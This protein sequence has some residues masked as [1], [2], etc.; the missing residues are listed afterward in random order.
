MILSKSN[1]PTMN[2]LYLLRHGIAVPHG[3]PGMN[4][5]DRP[6]TPKGE[7][8]VREVARGLKRIAIEVDRIATS[9]LPR[10]LSTARI[11]AQVI[12]RPEL[13]EVFDELRAGRDAASIRAWLL[14]RAEARLMI[15]G[16]NPT[17]SELL[18]W[19]TTGEEGRAFRELRKGGIAALVGD[20]GGSYRVD[21]IARPKLFRV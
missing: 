18:A 2:Q 13:V 20:P 7:R 5:D 1:R 6:L 21:W 4:D 9:P 15:V 17:L 10:A 12:G 11:V 3:T 8:R 14:G 16:H 19:L